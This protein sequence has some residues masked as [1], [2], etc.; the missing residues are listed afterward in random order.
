V[1]EVGG[2]AAGALATSVREPPIDHERAGGGRVAEQ[3]EAGGDVRVSERFGGG[4][5]RGRGQRGLQPKLAGGKGDEW[6][7]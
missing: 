5:E 3:P 7:A 4:D 2:A 1:Q 6:K